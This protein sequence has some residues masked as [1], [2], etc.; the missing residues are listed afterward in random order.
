MLTHLI[1]AAAFTLLSPLSAIADPVI[2]GRA[3]VVDGDTISIGKAKIRLDGIDAM[4]AS[5]AC[6]DREGRKYRCGQVAANALDRFLAASRPTS[7]T[8]KGQDR[9]K[10]AIAICHRA[11]GQEVN[12]WLVRSGHA[13][14]WSRYSKGRYA[15]DQDAAEKA[16]L[17]IWAG[18]FELPC[19]WR[20]A[21]S[22]RKPSC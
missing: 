20:A 6:T 2:N 13:L 16:A 21:K 4:E 9:Y 7:C 12:A 11:D 5:Q 10:R 19:E 1:A 17:G 3:A 8:V 14:D 18:S 22:G 15:D